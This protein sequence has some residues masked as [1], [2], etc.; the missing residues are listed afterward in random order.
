MKTYP[1]VEN[2]VGNTPLVRL[3][4]LPS[5]NA[6]ERGNIVLGKPGR[7]KTVRRWR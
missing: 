7:L 2:A 3:Q 1:S 6:Q 4:R 5:K